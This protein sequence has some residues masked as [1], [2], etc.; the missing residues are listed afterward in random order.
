VNLPLDR[1][2]LGIYDPHAALTGQADAEEV[3]LQWKP[4]IGQEVQIQVTRTLAEGRV[5]FV[6]IEPYPWN[7]DGLGSSTLLAD[8]SAGRYDPAIE[9]IAAA[10]NDASPTPVYIRFGH[11]MDLTGLYPW[12][13]GDPA[14]YIQAYRHFALT[15]GATAPNARFVWS[16]SGGAGSASYYPGGDVVDLIGVTVLVAQQWETAGGAIPSFTDAFNDRYALAVQFDK[17]LVIAELGIST[18][19]DAARLRWIQEVR[20][21]MSSYTL[22]V[23]AI[24]F[25]DRQPFEPATAQ[26]PDWRLS[27]AELSALFAPVPAR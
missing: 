19:D 21:S 12:S 15:V 9:A 5:P 16:P 11:E 22:L 7:V 4:S 10:V 24:W 23:G 20:A 1:P 13:Q 8:I 6:T 27:Q 18:S 3:F 25:D 26:F 17:P 2:F 14:A